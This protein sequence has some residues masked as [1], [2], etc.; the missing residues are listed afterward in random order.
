MK[1]YRKQTSNIY[2]PP[3]L[4][5]QALKVS[6]YDLMHNSIFLYP[7]MQY[8]K[9]EGSLNILQFCLAVGKYIYYVL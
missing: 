6:S 3:P 4:L 9:R 8:M 1:I 2:F 7:F 5:L